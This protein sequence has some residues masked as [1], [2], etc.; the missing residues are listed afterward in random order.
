MVCWVGWFVGM[1]VLVLGFV[2][3]FVV[4]IGLVLSILMFVLVDGFGRFGGFGWLVVVVR[5]EVVVV[6]CWLFV[7]IVVWV[8]IILWFRVVV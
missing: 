5:I 1:G 2:G 6:G 8:W 4:C 7:G 3:G